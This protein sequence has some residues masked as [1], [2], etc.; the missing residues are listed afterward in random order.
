[1]F[2][3]F[4]LGPFIS[5]WLDAPKNSSYVTY[6]RF[7]PGLGE[8]WRLGLS[9]HHSHSVSVCHSDKWKHNSASRQTITAS[10]W[11][12]GVFLGPNK[13]RDEKVVI[14]CIFENPSILL[15]KMIMY[16]H[17]NLSNRIYCIRP[18][19]VWMF[20]NVQFHW[21]PTSPVLQ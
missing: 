18:T 10:H 13:C 14:L 9:S 16:S 19:P 3:A 1:M 11:Q 15:G 7:V 17:P 12:P 8:V 20:S 4:V 2:G 6:Q 21:Q 5:T